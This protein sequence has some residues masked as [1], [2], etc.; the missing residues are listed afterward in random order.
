MTSYSILIRSR[1]IFDEIFRAD[2]QLKSINSS[3]E[4]SSLIV[5]VS[6]FR[7]NS[8]ILVIL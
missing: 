6:L 4:T 7:I 2:L 8:F 5:Q 3:E 1:E